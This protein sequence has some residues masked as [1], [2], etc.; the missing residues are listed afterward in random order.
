MPSLEGNLS[1]VNDDISQEISQ[2]R[3]SYNKD[4]LERL[5]SNQKMLF[6]IFGILCL[7]LIIFAGYFSYFFGPNLNPIITLALVMSI[8]YGALLYFLLKI[9]IEGV[10]RTINNIQSSIPNIVTVGGSNNPP[11]GQISSSDGIIVSDL[12]RPTGFETITSDESG[13]HAEIPRVSRDDSYYKKIIAIN[14]TNLEK[15]YHLIESQASKSFILSLGFGT[16]GFLFFIVA[17]GIGF[18]HSSDSS[19]PGI[20]YLSTAAGIVTE[21]I[22][23]IFISI[24]KQA[25]RS[26]EHYHDSLIDTQNALLSLEIIKE[27]ES[28]DNRVKIREKVVDALLQK[29]KNTNP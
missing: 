18:T 29:H 4:R 17:L 24:Y 20:S 3:L 25:T 23:A 12:V 11:E 6:P 1:F 19:I 9:K 28:E 13:A 21:I 22:T 27:C 26:L 5:K 7:F 2:E 15:N 16:V 10:E 14:V 8:L